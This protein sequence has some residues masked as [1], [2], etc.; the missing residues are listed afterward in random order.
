MSVMADS[1]EVQRGKDRENLAELLK[2]FNSDSART[3]DGEALLCYG[4][5]QIVGRLPEAEREEFYVAF[6]DAGYDLKRA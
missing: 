5:A 3:E 1:D 2:F 4:A 6:R